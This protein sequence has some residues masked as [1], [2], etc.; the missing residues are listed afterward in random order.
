[1]NFNFLTIWF[2]PHYKYSQKLNIRLE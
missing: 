1:L 2:C